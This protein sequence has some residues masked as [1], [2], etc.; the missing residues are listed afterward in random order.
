MQHPDKGRGR[1]YFK[2]EAQRREKIDT[3][4]IRPRFAFLVRLGLQVLIDR[5][6]RGGDF[7]ARRRIG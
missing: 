5:M 2:E 7:V 1:V 6:G 4:V 3:L